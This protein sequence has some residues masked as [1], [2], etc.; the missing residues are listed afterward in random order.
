[1][2]DDVEIR[3][4][5]AEDDLDA[6]LDLSDRAFGVRSAADRV[7][8]RQA[9]SAA[10]DEGGYL[11]AF[12]GPRAVG[13]ALFFDMRQWWLGRAVAMAGVSGVKV[14]PEDRGQGIGRALMTAL[15]AEIA[16]RGYP[17]SVLYPAT[18]PLY[19]SLGWELAGARNLAV[20]PA[21]SLRSL[22]APDV[23]AEMPA[24]VPSISRVPG[25]ASRSS[26]IA[27]ARVKLRRAG[28]DDEAEVLRVIGRAHELA[29]DCGAVTYAVAVRR[30]LSDP[31]IYTY[32]ADDGFLAYRWSEGNEEI[33][34]DRLLGASAETTR[35]LWS[36]VASHA[37]TAETVRA[38]VGPADP[39]WWLTRERDANITNRS[40]WMLR[41]VDAPA[42]IAARGFPP[43]CEL[44][45]QLRISDEARPV[46]SGLWELAV[47]GGKGF[48]SRASEPAG[49]VLT[50]GARG[51]AALYAGT[52]VATL[53]LAGL[54]TGGTPDDDASLD[55]A[56]AGTPYLLDSF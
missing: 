44:T 43:S 3:A 28:S 8:W 35:A 15:L 27:E 13:A 4:L 20:I 19:R 7:T 11:G 36:L 51:L 17:L 46:N 41:V 38:H 5:R 24:V 52:P 39:F 37:S 31:D 30:W 53:R 10:L 14:A 42:A 23:S 16:A 48:L 56:F 12:A 34:V 33:F 47:S 50:L 9:M 18:M 49:A 21:H 40:M 54:A 45:V 6:Q 25:V 2:Y 32:L 26:R 29:R 55:G 1:M 22:V